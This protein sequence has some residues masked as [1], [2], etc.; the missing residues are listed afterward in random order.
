MTRALFVTVI[1]TALAA[2]VM[3]ATPVAYVTDIRVHSTSDGTKV[4]VVEDTGGDP[5]V[6]SEGLKAALNPAWAPDGSRLAFQAIEDVYADIFVCDRDGGNRVNI[7]AGSAT[8]DTMP[9]FVGDADTVV[10]L[11]GPARTQVMLADLKTGSSRQLTQDA[12]FYKQPVALPDGSGVI[13]TG[14]EKV[15]GAGDIYLVKLDGTV[16]NLTQAPALYSRPTV[17]PDGKTVAFC[18]DRRDIGGATRGVASIPLAGGEPTLLASDGY[19]LAVLAYSP[20]GSKIAYT[21]A[22]RYNT[23]WV[24]LIDA[25]GSEPQRLKVSPYHIIAWPS[26]S[27]DGSKLAY[28]GCYAAVFT[29]HVVDLAGGEDVNLCVAAKTGVRP[30]YAPR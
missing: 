30:V 29:V 23:T 19:P 15:R 4:V 3:H 17:S 9:Q 8:F 26:F 5:I 1:V 2:S 25:A 6:V 27:P 28:H 22:S 11:S 20:D 12:L 21:S 7:T 13:V 18:Y 10:Y 16:A 14:L 24:N